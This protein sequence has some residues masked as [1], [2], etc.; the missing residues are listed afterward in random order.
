MFWPGVY[1]QAY[2][3]WV[4]L[5]LPASELREAVRRS[6]LGEATEAVTDDIVKLY[7]FLPVDV[8]FRGRMVQAKSALDSLIVDAHRVTGRNDDGDVVDEEH[9]GTWLGAMGYLALIDQLGKVLRWSDRNVGPWTSPF[10]QILEQHGKSRAEAAA[11]YALR[12]AMAHNYGLANRNANRPECQ[13]YFQ[14]R[15]LGGETLVKLPSSAWDGTPD[16]VSAESTTVVSLQAIGNLGEELLL[17]LQE[18]YLRD[19]SSLSLQPAVD[20][21]RI[22]Y[23]AFYTG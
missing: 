16:G 17:G 15:V 8:E 6:L 13:H 7:L 21:A 12:N 23:F 2:G 11:L 22:S 1:R 18:T 10:E 9:L 3:R 20:L 19:P 4:R 14:L 5:Q